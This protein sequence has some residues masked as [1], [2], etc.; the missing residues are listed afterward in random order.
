[1]AL[2]HLRNGFVLAHGARR[3]QEFAEHL[4]LRAPGEQRSQC[5]GNQLGGHHEHQAIRH[6][7]QASLDEDVGD[8]LRIVGADEII[9]DAEFSAELIGPRFFGEE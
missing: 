4:E 5:S 7:D 9:G 8:A 3:M 1:V 6:G 2:D